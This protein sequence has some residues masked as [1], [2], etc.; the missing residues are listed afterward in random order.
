MKVEL[1]DFDMEQVIGGL[2]ISRFSETDGVV[3]YNGTDYPFSDYNALVST[4]QTCVN[5]GQTDDA[6]FMAAL[7]AAGVI[8]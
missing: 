4:V 1:N 3:H 6:D 2:H 5:N 8:S 7:F